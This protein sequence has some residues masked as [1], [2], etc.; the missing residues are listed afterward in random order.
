MA[1][2]GLSG[3]D[4][5]FVSPETLVI[6]NNSM[7][8]TYQEEQLRRPQQYHHHHIQNVSCDGQ[9]SQQSTCTARAIVPR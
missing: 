8:D 6:D 7:S 3:G 5:L 4:T 2:L 1:G 9:Q